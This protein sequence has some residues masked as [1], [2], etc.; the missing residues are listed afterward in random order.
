MKTYKAALATARD[1]E[2]SSI[3]CDVCG[4]TYS[5]KQQPFELIECQSLDF[6]AGYGSVFGDSMHCEL[7]ICQHCLKSK[8]GKWIKLKQY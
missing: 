3:T 2:V 4:N 6:M 1:V 8:L 7:D 5:M